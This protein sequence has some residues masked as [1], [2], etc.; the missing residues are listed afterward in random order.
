MK[1]MICK[2][3]GKLTDGKNGKLICE[4]CG[5]SYLVGM[6][7]QGEPFTYQ[8]IEKKQIE[9]GKTTK[10][11]EQIPS[12][13]ITVRE[14][15]LGANIETDIAKEAV[16]LSRHESINVIESFL[17]TGEWDAAQ[18]QINK[19]L[20]E[21]A[22][23]S[24]AKWFSLMCAKHAVSDEDLLSK[25][26]DFSPANG[27]LLDEILA[28]AS[29]AFAKKLICL[30]MDGAYLN[31]SM[32]FNILSVILPYARNEAIF[33]NSEFE[34]RIAVT[35]DKVINRVFCNTFDFLIQ[36]A[37][38]ADD[39]DRYIDYVTKFADRCQPLQAQKYYSMVLDVNPGNLDVHR[40]LLFADLG[41]NAKPE[42]I[43]A[44]FEALAQ[45]AQNVDAEVISVLNFLCGET[46]TTENKSDAFWK[47]M[48]YHSG[49]PEASTG[50]IMRYASLLLASSLWNRARDYY[51]FILTIE[52][53]N[54]DAYFGLCLARLQAKNKA[55][56][57]NKK[58]S[59][60]GCPEFAKSLALYKSSNNHARV[61]ELEALISKQKNMQKGKKILLIAAAVVAVILLIVFIGRQISDY[62]KYSINNIGIELVESVNEPI[63]ELE[64]KFDN[65]CKVGISTLSTVIRFYDSENTELCSTNV[66]FERLEAGTTGT[67][68][69]NLDD[70]S[71]EA[72]YYYSFDEL[73]MTITITEI[74]YWDYTSDS[75]GEGKERVLKEAKE[76]SRKDEV[77]K[78]FEE[79]LSTFDAVDLSANDYQQQLLSAS[80]KLDEIWN[81]IARSPE[82]SNEMYEHAKDYYA[83]NEYEKAYFF[84]TMLSTINYKDSLQLAEESYIAASSASNAPSTGN[85]T[86]DDLSNELISPHAVLGITGRE[87]SPVN[88]N[89]FSDGSNL[90]MD[91]S[92]ILVIETT[93]GTDAADKLQAGDVLVSLDGTLVMSMDDITSILLNKA[94]GDIVKVEFYRQNSPAELLTENIILSDS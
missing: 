34:N 90:Y 14:I 65:G 23:S 17:K 25:L 22:N 21:D 62:Q 63:S 18:T 75:F 94:P 66:D 47:L 1:E 68:A 72:L 36:N 93:P 87:I 81:D 27:V 55:D 46:I 61:K 89:Y 51:H 50:Q 7:D 6:D 82:L 29:P 15:N 32:S 11:A 31:D 69:V 57:I 35:F 54:A 26:S 92:A 44:D 24:E 86:S 39:V 28:Y 3:G 13:L 8:Q 91:H 30:F 41:A 16:N 12:K 59:I 73:K 85:A 84:F 83:N 74:S 56:I 80:E 58:E 64:L 20:L 70:K 52:S 40:K 10:K 2:C 49:A 48:G 33:N 45:Y 5:T 76:S 78:L 53:K 71:Q 4:N 43:I 77:K 38:P 37:L 88:A 60:S 9:S 67:S 42:K 19:L 79:A